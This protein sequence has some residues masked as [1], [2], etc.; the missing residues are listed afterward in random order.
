MLKLCDLTRKAAG[1]GLI[2]RVTLT[3]FFVAVAYVGALACVKLAT[4]LG[5]YVVAGVVIGGVC[6]GALYLVWAL[7]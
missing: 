5:D 4:S 7:R 1:M 3:I 6:G 2:V